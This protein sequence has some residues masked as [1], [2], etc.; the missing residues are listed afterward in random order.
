M[1]G[2]REI[3]W[4]IQSHIEIGGG[5]AAIAL[6]NLDVLI[7]GQVGIVILNSSRGT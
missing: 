4:V 3:D 1:E 5:G 6:Q 2:D 7:D